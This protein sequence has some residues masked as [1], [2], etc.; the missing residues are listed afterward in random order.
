ME[1]DLLRSALGVFHFNNLEA[2][3]T[4]AHRQPSM[5]RSQFGGP[6]DLFKTRDGWIQVQ[7]IGMA[8]FRRW[9]RLVEAVD[10][11]DDPR[12]GSDTERGVHG[13]VLSERMQVWCTL[14]TTSDALDELAAARIPAGPL[15]SPHEVFNDPHV[16]ETEMLTPV[17]YEGLAVPAPLMGLPLRLSEQETGI[18]RRP[19]TLGEH[20]AMIFS[21]LGYGEA[22]LAELQAAGAI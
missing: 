19:P 4:G 8:L 15:L 20:N 3:L 13:Q 9:C 18:V 6:A 21:A 17:A 1:T 14:R 11:L 5:N 22:E 10:L 12:F 7:V 16:V 2:L